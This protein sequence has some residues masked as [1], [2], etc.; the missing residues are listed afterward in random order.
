MYEFKNVTIQNSED[1]EYLT[2][3]EGW[4]VI[5]VYPSGFKQH[6]KEFYAIECKAVIRKKINN[7]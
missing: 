6:G 3:E 4:E 1:L 7:D 2:N 5:S